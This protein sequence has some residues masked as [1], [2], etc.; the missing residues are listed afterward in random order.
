VGALM[1]YNDKSITGG[2]RCRGTLATRYSNDF[3]APFCEPAPLFGIER[4]G[5]VGR[6]LG[7]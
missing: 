7:F 1:W 3:A 2:N 5:A 6:T 4:N